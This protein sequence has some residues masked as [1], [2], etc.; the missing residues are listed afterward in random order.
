MLAC[1]H[2]LAQSKI[3]ED[4]QLTVHPS[5]HLE[6]TC[7]VVTLPS[8]R[9]PLQ[10]YHQYFRPTTYKHVNKEQN[11]TKEITKCIEDAEKKG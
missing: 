11:L 3:N 4:T 9:P 8:L 7:S 1:P 6:E 2:A 10:A 5:P